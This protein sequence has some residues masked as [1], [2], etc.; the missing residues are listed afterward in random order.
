[1]GLVIKMT[2]CTHTKHGLY[3]TNTCYILVLLI[4]NHALYQTNVQWNKPSNL[5][6]NHC[7]STP[8]V[9]SSDFA[10]IPSSTTLTSPAPG[11]KHSMAITQR[12]GSYRNM[13]ARKSSEHTHYKKVVCNIFLHTIETI[14]VRIKGSVVSP[15]THNTSCH[16][17]RST[18]DRLLEG[19]V[20]SVGSYEPTHHR[21]TL[22]DRHFLP[23]R[24]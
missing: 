8:Q 3:Y 23:Y 4:W 16:T 18:S 6:S 14:I 22:N 11:S 2:D 7:M 12:M 9:T 21:W 19:S 17:D 10:V 1:M 5:R 13:P 20:G 24:Q 15:D